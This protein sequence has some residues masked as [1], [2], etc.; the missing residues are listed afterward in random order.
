MKLLQ[1]IKPYKG[2]FVIHSAFR[3][4]YKDKKLAFLK[5]AFSHFNRVSKNFLPY[6]QCSVSLKTIANKDIKFYELSIHFR[7]FLHL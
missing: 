4:I 1:K 7:Y 6:Y 5:H 2:L 3:Y